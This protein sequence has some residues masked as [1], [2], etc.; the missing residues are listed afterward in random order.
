MFQNEKT[1][2]VVNNVFS[3]DVAVSESLGNW[4][5]SSLVVSLPVSK[6]WFQLH[7]TSESIVQGDWCGVILLMSS[8]SLEWKT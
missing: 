3:Q 8:Y 2:L 7:T 6:A 4:T 1:M 5:Q